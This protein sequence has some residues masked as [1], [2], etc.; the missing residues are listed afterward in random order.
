MLL[1]VSVAPWH[2]RCTLAGCSGCLVPSACAGV[3]VQ[4]G[5]VRRF[6]KPYIHLDDQPLAE[7]RRIRGWLHDERTIQC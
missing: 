6:V 4:F 3:P 7:D 5:T 1:F 2:V